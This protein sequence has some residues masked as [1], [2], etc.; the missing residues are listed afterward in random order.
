MLVPTL[1]GLWR[2]KRAL[3]KPL[4]VACMV[5]TAALTIGS[6]IASGGLALP[7]IG[8][9]LPFAAS[10]ALLPYLLRR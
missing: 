8:V 3:Y 2:A 7:I 1:L 4:I 10:L 5:G 6:I 9:I